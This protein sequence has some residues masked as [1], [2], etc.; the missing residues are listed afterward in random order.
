MIGGNYLEIRKPEIGD[1]V[2]S[3]EEQEILNAELIHGIRYGS[4]ELVKLGKCSLI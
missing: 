3:Q 1:K 2:P 4:Y